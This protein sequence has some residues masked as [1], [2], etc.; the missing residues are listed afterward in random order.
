MDLSSRTWSGISPNGPK[1]KMLKQ[2]QHDMVEDLTFENIL[3][4]Y[5]QLELSNDD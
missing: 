3:I 4:G 2:V 1:G 5:W